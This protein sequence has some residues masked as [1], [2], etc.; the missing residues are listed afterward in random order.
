MVFNLSE[1]LKPWAW[2]DLAMTYT[3]FYGLNNFNWL[4]PIFMGWM[5]LIPNLFKSSKVFVNVSAFRWVGSLVNISNWK[6]QKWFLNMCAIPRCQ[7]THP[8]GNVLIQCLVLKTFTKKKKSGWKFTVSRILKTEGEM[9]R[10]G[11]FFAWKMYT[12]SSLHYCTWKKFANL[13]IHVLP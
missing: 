12:T 11:Y 10:V 8:Y 9:V 1:D 5:T 7:Y 6:T 4:R 13:K 3:H 2:Y